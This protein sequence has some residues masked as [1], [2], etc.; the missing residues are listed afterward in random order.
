MLLLFL[1]TTAAAT[2]F[3]HETFEN[4]SAWTESTTRSDYEKMGSFSVTEDGELK[5]T[6][7]ARFYTSFAP[8]SRSIEQHESDFVV[9]YSVRLDNVD[10]KCG[11]GY[12]KLMEYNEDI[13]EINHETPYKLMFGPDFSCDGASKV[14]A[15][16]GAV[17]WYE[18]PSAEILSDGKEHTFTLMLR[19]DNT[20]SYYVDHEEIHGGKIE[21]A[22]A[23][24]NPQ[25]IKDPTISK[26]NDWPLP[27]ILDMSHVKPDGY[28]ELP[29]TVVDFT[30]VKPD[31]W[32]DGIWEPPNIPNPSYHG[33]WQQRS[34]PN[35]QYIKPW[36]HPT[37]SNPE[38][39]H[40]ATL[41]NQ[42]SGVNVIGF[43]LWNFDA[44]IVFDNIR[45][46][47]QLYEHEE[48]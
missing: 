45:V 35:P 16:F 29:L 1:L 46:S 25:Q 30:A 14:H 4:D 44:G 36:S 23:L 33:P 28:D 21:E 37:I 17:D 8:M 6:E 38:Y 31:D 41:Y 40:N 15:I 20:Y 48:M 26:P 13:S 39:V 18:T 32:D 34:I 7:K 24:N 47:D 12:L 2:D 3:F 43:E 22:W 10:F 5:T 11:G 19:S 42:F 9:Q 27:T